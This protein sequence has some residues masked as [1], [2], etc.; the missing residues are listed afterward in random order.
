VCGFDSL[1]FCHAVECGDKG[2]RLIALE[3]RRELKG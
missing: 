3:E 2:E 1:A